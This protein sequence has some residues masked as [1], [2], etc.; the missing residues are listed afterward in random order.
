MSRQNDIIK[1][2]KGGDSGPVFSGYAKIDLVFTVEK[3]IERNIKLS[4]KNFIEDAEITRFGNILRAGQW[5][6][7][8]PTCQI[9]YHEN[10]EAFEYN[11]QDMKDYLI[12]EAQ[13]HVEELDINSHFLKMTVPI[14]ILVCNAQDIDDDIILEADTIIVHSLLG[15]VPLKEARTK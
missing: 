6:Y 12:R 2:I 13:S 11:K 3:I 14:S 5:W 8:N 1:K 7:L 9:F 15:K 10:H 4:T